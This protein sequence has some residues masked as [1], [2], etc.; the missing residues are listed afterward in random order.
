M[1][2]PAPACR[3]PA[4]CNDGNPCTIDN[5]IDGRCSQ[6]ERS[7]ND[8]IGCTADRCD[9][10]TGQ[11]LHEE[12]DTFC[13]RGCLTGSCEAGEGCVDLVA[14]HDECARLD[15]GCV[16]G[17][18]LAGESAEFTCQ[19]VATSCEPGQ[20]CHLGS[21]ECREFDRAEC[22]RNENCL[23]IRP[24]C[25]ESAFCTDEGRC[26]FEGLSSG[27][28]LRPDAPCHYAFCNEEGVCEATGELMRCETEREC[29]TASCELTSDGLDCVEHPDPGA[30]CPADPEECT[31]EGVCDEVGDC[32]PGPS[33]CVSTP[34]E[35]FECR[36]GVCEVETSAC[37]GDLT[38]SSATGECACPAGTQDC[39]SDDRCECP[40][41]GVC[42]DESC[43]VCS[44]ACGVGQRCCA[45]NGRCC[46]FDDAACCP[47]DTT[48]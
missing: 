15:E 28:C 8:G 7:C 16:V 27:P 44:P 37:P 3:E 22:T 14:D 36:G 39:D 42:A 47:V 38:C 11:C 4:D 12:N 2:A 10:D 41:G 43:V 48:D 35:E 13:R 45:E 5:C 19:A 25:F 33:F 6:V 26:V 9:Q 29:H 18:C 21:G 34:C 32:I 46:A 20:F 23:A 24:Q 1:D 40:A 17:R 31:G 30:R